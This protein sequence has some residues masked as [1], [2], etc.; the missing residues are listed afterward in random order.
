MS[1][2][3]TSG[4]GWGVDPE[5]AAL[6]RAQIQKQLAQEDDQRS[7][8]RL[9]R[10]YEL[11]DLNDRRKAE[12]DAEIARS[13]AGLADQIFSPLLQE[14]QGG[15]YSPALRAIV[16]SAHQ[17][18]GSGDPAMVKQGLALIDDVGRKMT[19]QAESGLTNDVK[20]FKFAQSQGFQGSFADFL[21][22]DAQNR[23]QQININQNSESEYLKARAKSEADAYNALQA[24]AES[25]WRQRSSLDQFIKASQGG[26]EGGAADLLSG[27][28]NM[29]ASF[30]VNIDPQG[31]TDT[32]LM[33]QAIGNIL[34]SKMSELGARGLTDRD[35]DVL[36]QAL[37]RVAT[38][39]QS[40]EAIAEIL[41]KTHDSTIRQYRNRLD[42]EQ[43]RFPDA[44]FYQPTWLP[45]WQKA[46]TPQPQ[47]QI[48]VERIK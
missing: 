46:T 43:S 4:G 12:R 28:G 19:P 25:A 33:E 21:A 38:D 1:G 10:Q 9:D 15:S 34:G 14:T 42:W 8:E 6:W 47:A 48:K 17:M 31:L 2:F 22:Q 11:M 24:G 20:N 5:E 32:R 30:G 39:R 45:D 36:R 3:F 16:T 44:N 13:T 35:M 27:V 37:P 29:M 7:R 40:R 23:R 18:V 26:Y 41:K